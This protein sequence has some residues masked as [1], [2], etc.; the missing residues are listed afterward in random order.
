MYFHKN[1]QTS[2]ILK[3]VLEQEYSLLFMFANKKKMPSFILCFS[4]QIAVNMSSFHHH[5]P[6]F[7][8][9]KY[10]SITSK[11]F[12]QFKFILTLFSFLTFQSLVK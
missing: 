7:K 5:H 10:F 11:S 4:C 1:L 6:K 12:T 8:G 2:I 3:K 9:E